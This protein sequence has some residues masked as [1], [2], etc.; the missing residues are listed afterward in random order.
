[1]SE[2]DFSEDILGELRD[3][4]A[5]TC[6]ILSGCCRRCSPFVQSISSTKKAQLR[7]NGDE[8]G[9]APGKPRSE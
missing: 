9:E 4:G 8:K 3:V 1:M 2:W 6:P 5:K 7:H